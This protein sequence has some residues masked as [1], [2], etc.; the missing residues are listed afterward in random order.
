MAAYEYA[1][2]S[3]VQTRLPELLPPVPPSK[4][5][6]PKEGP[7]VAIFK[8]HP[9]GTVVQTVDSLLE[10]LN[11]YGAEGW[12]FPEGQWSGS[13]GKQ[14]IELVHQVDDS[15]YCY[16]VWTYFIRRATA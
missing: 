2:I 4:I 6:L 9:G 15:L 11:R 14:Q 12:I 13:P 10:G 1:F 5:G 16:G 8:S 3:I 7:T